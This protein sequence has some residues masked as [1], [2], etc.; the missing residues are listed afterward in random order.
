[1]KEEKL[2]AE[3]IG[4]RVYRDGERCLK[5]FGENYT[6][7]DVMN[8]ALN[9]ARVESTGLNVPKLLEVTTIEGNWTIVSEYIVG[10][11]LASLMEKNPQKYN[12]YMSLF[13]DLQL[14]IHSKTCPELRK[15]R[16]NLT[17]RI[18]DSPLLSATTKYDMCSRVN[19]MPRHN[20]LCHGDY[21]PSNIIIT[22]DGLPYIIDWSHST[23]GNSAAEAAMTYLYFLIKGENDNAETYLEM[24]CEKNNTGK[25]YLLKW[26][27][28]VAASYSAKCTPQE[29]EILKPWIF[30]T[31]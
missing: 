30:A 12:E 31:K 23:R 13:I 11:T 1:M 10:E 17:R 14:D 18:G 6:K 9:L 22:A 29:Y 28:I 26:M 8:E 5:V 4:K 25:D 3:R 21:N 2:I 15:L 27:P 16:D 20:K 19:D 7:A 24:F